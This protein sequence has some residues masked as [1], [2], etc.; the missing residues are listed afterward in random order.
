M[1]IRPLAG[2]HKRRLAVERQVIETSLL[3]DRN[4]YIQTYSDVARAGIDPLHHYL[5]VGWREGRDPG[6]MFTTSAYL[7]ANEDVAKTGLNPL[8]HFVQFGLAE[9]REG[10]GKDQLPRS[11]AG[12]LRD[13]AEP[14]ECLSVARRTPD[15]LSWRRGYRLDRSDPRFIAIGDFAA[16]YSIDRRCRTAVQTAVAWLRALSGWTES[17]LPGGNVPTSLADHRLLDAWFV[18]AVQLRTRWG[19]EGLPFV[20]RAFQCDP[21]DTAQPR[22]V[23]EG[24]VVSPLDFVDLHLLNS[25]FPILFVLAAPD[26]CIR[27]VTMLTFPSLCRGGLHYP[28]LLCD[29]APAS[30]PDSIYAPGHKLTQRFI[31]L[32]RGKA[33]AAVSQIQI[34]FSSADMKGPLFRCD[35]RQWLDR[36]LQVDVVGT[37]PPGLSIGSPA[38][39]QPTTGPAAISRKGGARLFVAANSAPTIASLVALRTNFNG[40]GNARPVPL[41]VSSTD[42][43]K[44]VLL[45]EIPAQSARGFDGFAGPLPWLFPNADGRTPADFPPAAIRASSA[46]QLSDAQLLL[47]LS[48][49][50]LCRRDSRA[51][52]TWLVCPELWSDGQLFQWLQTAALQKFSEG[53]EVAL[54][55]ASGESSLRFARGLFPSR[56]AVFETAGDA[57]RH[58][59][60][61]LAGHVGDGVL[62]HDPRIAD[63]FASL[64]SVHRVTTVSCV[65]VSA[66]KRAGTLKTAILE[67]GAVAKRDGRVASVSECADVAAELWQSSYPVVRPSPH[68]WAARRSELSLWTDEA[69][70]KPTGSIIHLCSSAVTATCLNR[71]AAAQQIVNLPEAR[72]TAA[73]VDWLVG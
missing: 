68:L 6:P 70:A 51:A 8:L 7:K 15:P 52:I 50:K 69:A 55:G 62:L 59:K 9:G 2:A 58:L 56:A 1:L 43:S 32:L 19:G 37:E 30:S 4:W 10:F 45:V 25:Y 48:A 65:I 13:F 17:E 14:Q 40:E 22:L 27:G 23:G 60:T 53:D 71:G 35:F 18:N 66:E 73:T 24:A 54:I 61:P 44:K 72:Q 41:L 49:P 46:Q 11:G 36:V 67:G 57:I 20:L 63:C 64:L 12:I 47:P 26:D 38:H 42:P 39:L 33:Q 31:A 29:H 21:M 5:T 16:G 3:F 28:E 34:D